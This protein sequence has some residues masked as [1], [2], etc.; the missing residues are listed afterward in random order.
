SNTLPR[1]T[2]N[3]ISFISLL[4]V[5]GVLGLVR[6]VAPGSTSPPVEPQALKLNLI[7]GVLAIFIILAGRAINMEHSN[8]TRIQRFPIVFEGGIDLLGYDL[9]ENEVENGDILSLTL[10]WE[11]ARPNLPDYQIDVGLVNSDSGQVVAV[12]RHRAP[13]DRATSYWQEGH[14][15]EDI[16]YLRLPDD[17]SAGDYH[18]AVQVLRCRSAYRFGE[19]EEPQPLQAFDPRGTPAGERVNLPERLQASGG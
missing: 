8:L 1:I 15:V 6:P 5:F 18:L 19:C 4:A 3:I 7:V 16:Y 12:Q 11:A 13:G 2:G 14:Y 9:P 10:F 17:L